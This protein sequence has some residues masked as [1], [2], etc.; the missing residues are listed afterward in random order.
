MRRHRRANRARTFMYSCLAGA[1]LCTVLFPSQ[2]VEDQVG[3]V[4]VEIWSVAMMVSSLTA[5][6]G[7]V[8]DRWIGEYVAL[9]LLFTVMFLYGCSALLGAG[10]NPSPLFAYGLV[11]IAFSAGLVARWQDVVKVKHVA[12]LQGMDDKSEE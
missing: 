8:T 4:V 12:V 2:L 10:L 3:F 9:P 11:V 1:G 7:A 6:Y 5:L